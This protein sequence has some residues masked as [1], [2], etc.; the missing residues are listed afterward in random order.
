MLEKADDTDDDDDAAHDMMSSVEPSGEKIGGGGELLD[1]SISVCW[2]SV[3]SSI[4]EKC[5]TYQNYKI[6]I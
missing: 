2:S 4:K 3:N 6:N 5:G 1:D